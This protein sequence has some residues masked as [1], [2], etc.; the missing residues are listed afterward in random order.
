MIRGLDKVSVDEARRALIKLLPLQPS[1]RY[2]DLRKFN[3]AQEQLHLLPIPFKNFLDYRFRGL[4]WGRWSRPIP[5]SL[6]TESRPNHQAVEPPQALGKSKSSFATPIVQALKAA[7]EDIRIYKTLPRGEAEEQDGVKPVRPFNLRTSVT[8]EFGQVLVPLTDGKVFDP[9]RTPFCYAFP[10][11]S[12]MLLNENLSADAE[13]TA[14]K[15]EYEFVANPTQNNPL[16]NDQ[17]YP[18]LLMQVRYQ[19]GS[20]PVLHGVRLQSN[21]RYHDV[22]LPDKSVDVRFRITQHIEMT[23]FHR[24][25]NVKEFFEE[26]RANIKSGT[27]LTAPPILQVLVPKSAIPGFGPKAKGERF[28]EYLFTGIRIGQSVTSKYKDYQLSYSAVRAGKLG[29]RGGTLAMHYDVHQDKIL[30][31]KSS[32]PNSLK[33]FVDASFEMANILTEAATNQK[34]IKKP[35]DMQ[36]AR[37]LRRSH[38]LHT[39]SAAGEGTDENNENNDSLRNELPETVAPTFTTEA[40][41][42]SIE[43]DARRHSSMIEE[44]D[45]AD[46]LIASFLREEHY[47]HEI[48]E[49]SLAEDAHKRV[50]AIGDINNE[51]IALGQEETPQAR[52]KRVL[53]LSE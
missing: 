42:D 44:G 43:Q 14:P 45:I 16:K 38:T 53:Q 52:K 46:P 49:E 11:L 6:N 30:S 7:R 33:K 48:T 47:K 20:N 2:I 29:K 10:G 40:I 50:T 34:P 36:S 13:T 12:K 17:K 26:I 32:K 15:L 4:D 31:K 8:A 1:P 21:E 18:N 27:R 39:S 3:A 9:L 25:Q 23:E 5:K 51:P 24:Q 35:R 22:L 41:E 37:K 19:Q 28:L